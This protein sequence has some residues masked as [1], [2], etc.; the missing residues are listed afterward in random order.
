M[1]LEPP[2][3]FQSELIGPVVPPGSPV[4]KRQIVNLGLPAGTLIILI[5]EGKEQ[6]VPDGSTTIEEN[7]TLLPLTTSK[8]VDRIRAVFR[9]EEGEAKGGGNR[10]GITPR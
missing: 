5:A 7:D 6:C 9:K 10:P 8:N 2:E 4:I 1:E 3:V